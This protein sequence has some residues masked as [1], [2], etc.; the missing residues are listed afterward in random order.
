MELLAPAGSWESMVAAVFAG[1]DAVYL[2][3]GA[4][5]ARRRAVNFELDVASPRSLAAAVAFCHVRGVQVHLA[6]NTL[7]T[8]REL[9]EALEVA[10]AAAAAG[11]D[12]L[13]VQDRGLARL[14][15]AACPTLPLH[16]STQLTCHTPSGVD[17]LR[18]DGF[19]RVVLSREMT[20]EEIAACVGRGCEVEVF[21]HG[22]LCM[23]VSGQCELSAFL[24]GRSGNR[25]LC[26]QPCRLPFAAGHFP[27]E[28]A[29]LSLKDNSLYP[30]VSELAKLG[31]DSLKIEGRMKRPEYVAAAVAV[32]RGALDGTPPDLQLQNDLKAV[33]SRHGFTDGYFTGKRDGEMFGVRRYEDVQAADGA[34]LSRLSRLYEKE[35]ARIPVQLTLAVETD[36]PATLVA[37][38]G[39]YT[40]TV[41]GELPQVAISRPLSPE[42]ATEQLQ[43]T[44]GTPYRATVLCNIEEGLTLPASAL[45]ALRREALEQ[46]TARRGAP[47]AIPFAP[48][49]LPKTAL[50]P[51]ETGRLVARVANLSQI[52]GDADCWVVPLG[53]IPNVPRWWVE[54]PRGMFGRET[55]IL[56]ALRNAKE[57]G[58]AAAVC[59]TVGAFPLAVEAGLSPVAGWSMHITNVHALSAAA[60]S[61]AVA[62]VASVELSL[63]QLAFAKA[64]GCGVFAYGRQPLMLMR[65]CPV[66]AAKGCASCGGSLTDRKG[67]SFPVMCAGGCSELLNSVPLYLADRLDELRDFAFLYLHFTDESPKRVAQV[68]E[69]YRNGG[70]PPAEFTRGKVDSGVQ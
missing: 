64:G 54:I 56:S 39:T 34:V 13:I 49:D 67:V 3:A 41:A 53:S 43:K 70:H 40:V 28:E 46:L 61:G 16:A 52:E 36:T 17:R 55:E 9:P 4:F 51:F 57:H 60:E 32:F 68:V 69:E 20:K 21:V 19:S 31:V 26:A 48:L 1:A 37:S 59:P 66:S 10:K 42:R 22:A 62:A 6:L 58:A 63:P 65:N 38:D 29:A 14:L 35:P 47:R 5:N 12:A 30:H 45:N 33:F 11:V 15:K 2:G 50:P 25:G 44:G 8:Q 7:I 23:S 27:K 18:E 24:G